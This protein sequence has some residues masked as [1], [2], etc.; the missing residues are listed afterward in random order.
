VTF[1]YSATNNLTQV[2]DPAGGVTQFTYD[3]SHRVTSITLP[4]S[5]VLLQ[6]TY[7][8]AGRV[9]TQTNGRSFTTTLAYN[10]PSPGSTTITDAR[11][12]KTVHTYDA[13]LRITTITDALSEVVGYTYDANNDRISVTNQNGKTTT[14][15]YDGDGNVTGLTDPLG[16]SLGFVSVR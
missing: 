10:T 8:S 16:N 15:A 6:N 3:A 4:N 9:I 5:Q 13:S 14:F 1:S 7:D 12:K 11:G 2:T